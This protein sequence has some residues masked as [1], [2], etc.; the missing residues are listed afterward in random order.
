MPEIK[1]F[2]HGQMNKT[3]LVLMEIIRSLNK[4]Q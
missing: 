1:L 3:G 4:Q 2:K